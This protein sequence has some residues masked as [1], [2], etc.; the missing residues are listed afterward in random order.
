M[1]QWEW[2]ARCRA[3]RPGELIQIAAPDRLSNAAN[4]DE[5]HVLDAFDV[6]GEGC[7]MLRDHRDDRTFIAEVE[8]MNG[9]LL[10]RI[11]GHNGGLVVA[12]EDRARRVA[13]IHEAIRTSKTWADFRLAIPPPG[14]FGNPSLLRPR[15]RAQA[16]EWIPPEAAET[17]CAELS[18]MGWKVEH[19]PEIPFW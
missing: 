18:A 5:D 14:V 4:Q 19:A 10:Y 13:R 11:A 15:R 16:Q 1:K 9:K 6:I 12:T 17:I 7:C 8:L 3:T 2:S